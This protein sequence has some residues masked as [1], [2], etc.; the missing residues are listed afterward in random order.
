VQTMGDCTSRDRHDDA[1]IPINRDEFDPVQWFTPRWF[2]DDEAPNDEAFLPQPG[3][4][5]R[6]PGCECIRRGRVMPN[7][8]QNKFPV[9][10]R[11]P[12][13]PQQLTPRSSRSLR[14]PECKRK[15]ADGW[16]WKFWN[17][18]DGWQ[19][20]PKYSGR[21]TPRVQKDA[22]RLGADATNPASDMNEEDECA[23]AVVCVHL[24]IIRLGK[25]RHAR[26]YETE[27]VD[28]FFSS[29]SGLHRC[30]ISKHRVVAYTEFQGRFVEDKI[31]NCMGLP[32]HHSFIVMDLECGC[33]LC[34]EKDNDQL[35]FMLGAGEDMQD[36]A[37]QF[38]ATGTRRRPI[39][40]TITAMPTEPITPLAL[41]E[42]A[43]WIERPAAL[44]EKRL[45]GLRDA[46]VARLIRKIT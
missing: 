46:S 31:K 45:D 12:S 25:A 34:A 10:K 13:T 22:N 7:I 40:T 41:N 15:E 29:S 28:K 37:K 38:H 36:F 8:P 39:E 21:Q 18:E 16:I 24:D 6:F 2:T 11:P 33:H 35:E 30:D 17:D 19:L 9:P 3:F 27:T 44:A 14:S 4:D 20:E 43:S 26:L 5:S 1:V 32:M 42:L 23:P